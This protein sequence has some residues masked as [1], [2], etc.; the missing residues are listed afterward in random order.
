MVRKS[1]NKIVNSRGM[2]SVDLVG[3]ISNY[4]MNGTTIGK[5]TLT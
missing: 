1:K 2:D 3:E 4:I 5:N